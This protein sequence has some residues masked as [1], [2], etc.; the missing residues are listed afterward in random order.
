MYIYIYCEKIGDNKIIWFYIEQ[1]FSNLIKKIAGFRT[2]WTFSRN[3]LLLRLVYCD[4]QFTTVTQTQ[5]NQIFLFFV[6]VISD[7]LLP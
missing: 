4:A 5:W 7:V 6:I 2:I 1:N 3:I